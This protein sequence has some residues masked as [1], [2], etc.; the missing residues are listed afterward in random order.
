[1][2]IIAGLVCNNPTLEENSKNIDVE[3]A[4]SNTLQVCA[5]YSMFF[6]LKMGQLKSSNS[7]S[8][9][10]SYNDIISVPFLHF[11]VL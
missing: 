10:L 9:I 11:L 1:M 2:E 4:S 6:D 7:S 8:V 5:M 3:A